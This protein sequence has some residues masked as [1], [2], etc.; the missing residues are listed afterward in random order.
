MRRRYPPRGRVE[1]PYKVNEKIT[2]RQVRVVGENVE[3][4]VFPTSK[5]LQMA[6]DQ[7]LDLVE[8]SPK[9]DPPVCKVIDY[10]KFKYEQKKKQ[11]EI[12]A[13][14]SKTVIKEIRF[15]PNTDDHDFE[16]KLK[17]AVNFLKEGA[18][19]KA[20]VHFKGRTIVYKERGE[21][22]LLKFAQALE[23]YAKVEQLPKLEGK[24]MFLFLAPKAAGKK[25]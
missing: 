14:A 3:Q 19:V 4:G 9:A 18:K 1:E 16:F 20:Y 8:I 10:S 2:A 15:G 22:L 6:K 13:K 21:I 23:E 17:H 11:K 12:K 7:S 24:R 5:A 25:S